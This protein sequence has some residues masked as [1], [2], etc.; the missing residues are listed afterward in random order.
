MATLKLLSR[1]ELQELSEA[2][3]FQLVGVSDYEELLEWIGKFNPE[4][5]SP[6]LRYN[7]YL[8]WYMETQTPL[9]KALS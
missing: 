4:L 2:D 3:M 9:G 1:G 8:N 5:T 6:G 7:A